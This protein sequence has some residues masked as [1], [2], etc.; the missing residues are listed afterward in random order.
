MFLRFLRALALV[1]G[2]VERRGAVVSLGGV[3]L[4]I[5][6]R[7]PVTDKNGDIHWECRGNPW[8]QLAV[9]VRNRVQGRAVTELSFVERVL[10]LWLLWRLH[11]HSKRRT[12]EFEQGEVAKLS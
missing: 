12:R 11:A 3:S 2:M 4:R 8:R 5:E 10:A 7:K 1:K 9:D 6:T